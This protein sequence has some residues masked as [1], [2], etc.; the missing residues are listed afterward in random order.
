MKLFKGILTL[1]VG[2]GIVLIL[3]G[4]SAIGDAKNKLEDAGYTIEKLSDKEF[5]DMVEDASENED[6]ELIKAIYDVYNEDDENIAIIIE[7]HDDESLER[8]F[9]ALDE[10]FEYFDGNIYENLYISNS[11]LIDIIKE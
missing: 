5:D 4:C 2:F 9:E 1:F 10:P 3:S 6:I 8:Y 7:F 11:S